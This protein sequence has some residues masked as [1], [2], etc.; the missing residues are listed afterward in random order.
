MTDANPVARTLTI[1]LGQALPVSDK[2]TPEI[3]SVWTVSGVEIAL[4]KQVNQRRQRALWTKRQANRA[5]PL[6]VLS[7]TGDTVLRV[8]GP[9]RADEPIREVDVAGLS[10][11]LRS[12]E[13]KSRQQA[14]AALAAELERMDR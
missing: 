13:G 7:S 12:L 14:A 11:L 2:D 5:T 3:R 6:L 9:L 10:E 4:A 1:A 8:L